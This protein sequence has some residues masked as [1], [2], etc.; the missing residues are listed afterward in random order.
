MPPQKQFGSLLTKLL[1]HSSQVREKGI[2]HLQERRG[3]APKGRERGAEIFNKEERERAA[4][5]LEGAPLWTLLL[6]G[7]WPK[8]LVIWPRPLWPLLTHACIPLLLAPL[9]R[10]ACMHALI[11]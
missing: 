1:P 9:A 8:P 6:W 4:F 11:F 5:F 3:R 2:V 10:D 7:G